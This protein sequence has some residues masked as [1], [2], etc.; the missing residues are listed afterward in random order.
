MIS[1]VIVKT[2]RCRR[3]GLPQIEAAL[4]EG[5]SSPCHVRQTSAAAD[6]FIRSTAAVLRMKGYCEGK[7]TSMIFVSTSVASFMDLWSED[8]C[9]LLSSKTLPKACQ[10][11]AKT[12]IP[13]QSQKY[14]IT[15]PLECIKLWTVLLMWLHFHGSRAS[16]FSWWP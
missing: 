11:D 1:V 3:E 5:I 6:V 8:I 16:L 4:T 13:K 7:V 10:Y 9:Q 2:M 15:K 12:T 14:K